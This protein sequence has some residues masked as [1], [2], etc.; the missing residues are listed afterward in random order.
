MVLLVKAAAALCA[1]ALVGTWF[2]DEVKKAKNRNAPWY[3][4]YLSPPGLI[5]LAALLAPVLIKLFS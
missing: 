5:I 2:L 4:P 1:A 3:S